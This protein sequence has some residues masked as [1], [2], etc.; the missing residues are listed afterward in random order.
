MKVTFFSPFPDINAFGLRTLAYYLHRGGHDIQIIFLPDP[1]FDKLRSVEERDRYAYPESLMEQVEKLAEGSDLVG[2]SVFTAYVVQA[3]QLSKR[4]KKLNVPVLWGGK[5]PSALPEESIKYADM[6]CIG[7]GEEAALELLDKMQKGVDYTDTRNFWFNLPDGS[8]KKNP[9]RPL[10][11]DIDQFPIPNY[12]F[13]PHFIW[14][15]DKGTVV[16]LDASIVEKFMLRDP[17]SK[18]R[19][20]RVYQT[21]MTR[22]C[23]FSC[24]Y[25][26][27]FKSLYKGQRYVRHRDIEDVISEIEAVKKTYGFVTHVSLCDD[28]FLALDIEKIREFTEKYKSRI[29]LSLSCLASPLNTSDEK[30]ALLA[31]AGLCAIQMGIQTLSEAGKKVYRRNISN[32]KVM[33]AV[34]SIHRYKGRVLP[35]FDFII[36]NPYESK[37]DILE[38]LRFITEMPRPYHLNLFSL[39]LFP[40]TELYQKA[41]DDGLITK[42][43][44]S[45]KVYRVY[46]KK[47]LNLIFQLLNYRIPIPVIKVLISKPAMAVFE[48]KVVNTILF[49]TIGILRSTKILRFIKRLTG[50]RLPNE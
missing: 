17:F 39:T 5:H 14:L 42:D 21:M 2:V 36:D 26:Y 9:V 8:V 29:G 37:D 41:L 13:C 34:E 20:G 24:T 18:G 11:Q 48:T 49:S 12:T 7:E 30:L 31:D 10:T 1:A 32:A 3:V 6:V 44:Y 43:E 45:M 27:T 25:C 19:E 22:G 50:F 38:T 35:L 15:K 46:E 40:G 28:E 23:P 33:A 16:P 4:F 47:Y